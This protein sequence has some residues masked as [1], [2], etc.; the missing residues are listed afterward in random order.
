VFITSLPTQSVSAIKA[1]SP[2][3]AARDEYHARDACTETPPAVSQS[4]PATDT[5]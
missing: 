4:T 2:P 5:L 3:A 1:H